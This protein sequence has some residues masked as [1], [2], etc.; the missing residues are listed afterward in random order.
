MI[1]EETYLK[2][3]FIIIPKTIFDMRGSFTRLFCR[4][5]FLEKGI[6][7]EFVQ[8]NHSH[9]TLKGTIRGLHFQ[10]APNLEAKLVRCIKGAVIDVIVDLRKDSPTYLQH[11]SIE[12]SEKNKKMLFVPENFAHGFQTLEDDTHLLYQTTEYYTPS[13]ESGLRFDD[14]VLAIKWPLKA[15]NVSEKD[16]NHVLLQRS[17]I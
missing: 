9:N 7:K 3:S 1:F 16:Q 15:V 2:N 6:D 8:V 4:R 11:F 14:P 13:S 10:F 12:L 5:E 17:N